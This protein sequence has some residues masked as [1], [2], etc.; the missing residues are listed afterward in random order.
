MC[1]CNSWKLEILVSI[2]IQ[3]LD[4]MKTKLSMYS[5]G[6]TF[7]IKIM[8]ALQNPM[9]MHIHRVPQTPKKGQVSAADWKC[10]SE[11]LRGSHMILWWNGTALLEEHPDPFIHKGHLL[12]TPLLSSL[13][14]FH[15]S[16]CSGN[17]SKNRDPAR[18]RRNSFPSAAQQIMTTDMPQTYQLPKIL[19]TRM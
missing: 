15:G 2:F 19:P 12:L 1:G 9:D 16:Y 11:I 10:V 7:I 4:Q 3:A 17:L 5:K 8:A 6:F 14:Q 13:W 18:T